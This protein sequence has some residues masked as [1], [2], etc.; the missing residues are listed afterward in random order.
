MKKFSMAFLT[1]FLGGAFFF[2]SSFAAE[3][4]KSGSTGQQSATQSQQT[5]QGEDCY[6]IGNLM[7]K[8]VKNQQGEELGELSEITIDNQG[9]VNYI[10]LKKDQTIGMGGDL[11]PIPW[12]AANPVV[13]QDSLVVNIEKQ[14]LEGAPTVQE[15]KLSQMSDQRLQQQVR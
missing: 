13:Q 5:S 9:V 3:H 6:Q 2:G 11:T 15:D 14:K 7:G 4:E 10:L 12:E 1:V 8:T